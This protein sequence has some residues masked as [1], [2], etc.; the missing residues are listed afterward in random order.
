MTRS[1]SLP[2]PT[3]AILAGL[4]LTGCTSDGDTTP[5]PTTDAAP[6]PTA[7]PST[8]TA[9]PE[10]TPAP[11]PT[12]PSATPTGDP[13]AALTCDALLSDEERSRPLPEG[14]T[15]LDDYQQKVEE[16]NSPL[17]LFFRF[18]GL[19][20][21][22]GYERTDNVDVRAYS[23]LTEAQ[24]AEA[25]AELEARG[26]APTA[27]GAD[28]VYREPAGNVLGYDEAYVITP[29]AWYYGLHQEWRD[30]VRAELID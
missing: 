7:A 12:E 2:V 14:V 30:R 15:L 18:G 9:T 1:A 17:R 27:E 28:T 10:P 6:T 19:A 8:P 3:L 16:E 25:R 20:C 24:A 5:P 11:E 26:F 21:L 22:W 23:P 4:L 13:A 29:D